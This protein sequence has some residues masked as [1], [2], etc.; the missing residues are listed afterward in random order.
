VIIDY[1][2]GLQAGV[3]DCIIADIPWAYER[4]VTHAKQ[5]ELVPYPTLAD[6][7]P[8]FETAY[9][10]L[11]PDRNLWVWSDWY[12]LPRLLM[13]AQAVG[14]VYRGLCVVKRRN[15]GLGYTLRKQIYF[16]PL[17]SKGKAYRN[18]GAWLSEYLG[19]YRCPRSHKPPEVY[20]RLL[21]HSLPLGGQ[22]IDPFPATHEDV[23]RRPGLTR[24]ELTLW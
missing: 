10:T 12:T 16:L 19:E 17:W 11:R 20:E 18:A 5:K 9:A 14:F 21:A 22:W 4:G 3:W 2:E 23:R 6:P 8:F 13:A 15:L 24:E 1:Q 7:A